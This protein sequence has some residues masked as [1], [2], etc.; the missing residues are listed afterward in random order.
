MRFFN[1]A[2]LF[3]HI[4]GGLYGNMPG[5]GMGFHGNVA[6]ESKDLNAALIWLRRHGAAI[7]DVR[8]PGTD[9]LIQFTVQALRIEGCI[10]KPDPRL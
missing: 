4:P 1:W 7:D 10:Y 8:E 9:R 5:N 3:D 2:N 6:V